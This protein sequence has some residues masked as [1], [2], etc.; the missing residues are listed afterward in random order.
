PG[1]DGNG[2][3]QLLEP[4]PGQHGGS[5][6][7]RPAVLPLTQDPGPSSPSPSCGIPCV[8]PSSSS[9]VTGGR[10]RTFAGAGEERSS[11]ICA[12]VSARSEERRVGKEGRR[13]WWTDH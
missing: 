12:G 3:R 10:K 7:H 8:P 1:L 4:E 5:G 9:S 2:G 13:R 6:R 11:A